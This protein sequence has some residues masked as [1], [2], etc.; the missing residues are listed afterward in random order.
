MTS[1]LT[2]KMPVADELRV[3]R[4]KTAKLAATLGFKAVAKSVRTGGPL[5]DSL[6]FMRH[7]LSGR[8]YKRPVTD[9]ERRINAKVDAIQGGLERVWFRVKELGGN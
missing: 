2:S 9:A 1:G 7:G 6:I 3:I 8:K 4:K 5:A